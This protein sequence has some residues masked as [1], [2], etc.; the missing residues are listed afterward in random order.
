MSTGSPAYSN[1]SNKLFSSQY[2]LPKDARAVCTIQDHVPLDFAEPEHPGTGQ[3]VRWDLR[4]I[5]RVI[6]PSTSAN[7]TEGSPSAPLLEEEEHTS[8]L[9][10]LHDDS[11]K[12]KN[13]KLDG[14]AALG[15]SVGVRFAPVRSSTPPAPD[16]A[17]RPAASLTA[18]PRPRFST[19][20]PS[21]SFPS[22]RTPL[23][24]HSHIPYPPLPNN[25]RPANIGYFPQCSF[26]SSGRRQ[27]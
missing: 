1:Q 10:R 23:A 24:Y 25:L 3:T 19:F 17:S 15:Q 2:G 14:L 8:F 16:P 6:T 18:K 5:F 27:L 20:P 12:A 9:D 4:D 13:G 22:A 21:R 11:S 26:N 7:S